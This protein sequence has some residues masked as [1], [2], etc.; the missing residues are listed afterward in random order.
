[1]MFSPS[2]IGGRPAL[3]VRAATTYEVRLRE[4][5]REQEMGL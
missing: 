2:V 1:M 4:R 3:L 5:Q